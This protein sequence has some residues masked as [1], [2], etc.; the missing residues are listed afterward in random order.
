M[1]A[2][3]A[4]RYAG[5]TIEFVQ[6]VPRRPRRDRRRRRTATARAIDFRIRGVQLRE[7]RDYLWRTY[8]RRRR[9]LVPEGQYIHIDSRPSCTTRRG[10][11]CTARITT[12]R[13]GPSSPASPAR[14]RRAAA[15]RRS[16]AARIA[17]S[18]ELARGSRR[19]LAVRAVDDRRG[20]S[21]HAA[22]GAARLARC[23][24]AR[25]PRRCCG[26]RISTTRA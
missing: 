3:I 10:R 22:V 24:R 26:S 18:R 19:D 15:A 17:A 1:L 25:R 2:D 23:A 5:K 21:G 12:I 13:T 7:I 8:T 11:S 20:A 6:R 4:E 9:R 16:V 14:G